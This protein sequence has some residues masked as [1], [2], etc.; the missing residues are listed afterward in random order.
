MGCPQQPTSIRGLKLHSVQVNLLA[1][2]TGEL[3][4]KLNCKVEPSLGNEGL[5]QEVTC[6]TKDPGFKATPFVLD[7]IFAAAQTNGQRAN[8]A[9]PHL[10]KTK[11]LL[12]HP[13]PRE[14][15]F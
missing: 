2:A 14:L 4:N 12:K 3:V 8:Q 13:L 11:D 5:I 10:E 1:L 7:K 15:K 9:T 6:W